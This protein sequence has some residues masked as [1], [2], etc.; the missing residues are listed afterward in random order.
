MRFRITVLFSLLMF[1]SAPVRAIDITPYTRIGGEELIENGI[2]EGHKVFYLLG[3]DITKQLLDAEATFRA[4]GFMMGEAVDEDPELIH[5]GFR[6]GGEF[7]LTGNLEPF[8]GVYYEEW[9]RDE[10]AKYP[11]SFT[12]LDFADAE[13]GFSIEKGHVYSRAAAIYPFWSSDFNGELGFDAGIGLKFG[14]LKI[15]YNYKRIKFSDV[16]SNFSAAEV[17]YTF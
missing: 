8:I 15:G 7:K 3:V 6:V 17:S 9:N 11:G 4:E 16:T 5:N 12:Q 10:N 1:L 14:D 13:L 2:S